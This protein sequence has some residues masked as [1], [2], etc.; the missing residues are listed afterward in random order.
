MKHIFTTI[1]LVLYIL[2]LFKVHTETGIW[3]TLT[4]FLMTINVEVTNLSIKRIN[5]R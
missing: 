4:I 1:R 3:T 2:I 5:Q